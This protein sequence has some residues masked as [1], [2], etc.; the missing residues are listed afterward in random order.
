MNGT[1]KVQPLCTA[2][3]R[4]T[5][6][7]LLLQF[8]RATHTARICIARYGPATI[9]PSVCL[10]HA[11][12]L[13]QTSALIVRKPSLGNRGDKIN[14]FIGLVSSTTWPS[15]HLTK[16]TGLTILDFN[17]TSDD[18]VA[19]GGISWTICKSFA[20]RSS[21]NFKCLLHKVLRRSRC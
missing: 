1:T 7:S 15:R 4:Q 14:P 11:D 21:I 2:I 9:R 17:E 10:S 6:T 19:A 5:D 8:Y 3:S 13:Y 16:L 20:H 12:I 18:G